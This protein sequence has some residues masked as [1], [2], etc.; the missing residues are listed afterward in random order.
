M[1]STFG[2][3]AVLDLIFE[4]EDDDGVEVG[5]QHYSWGTLTS[6]NPA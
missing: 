6:R 3:I 1:Q 4:I 2:K 5:A